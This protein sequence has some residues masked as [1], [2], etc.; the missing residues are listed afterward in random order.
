MSIDSTQAAVP[1]STAPG[2]EQATHAAML[3]N[4]NHS[5]DTIHRPVSRPKSA[6]W[7]GGS[8]RSSL[9]NRPQ[10][11]RGLYSSSDDR[12]ETSS[13]ESLDLD[14]SERPA[15]ARGRHAV[16][17]KSHSPVPT[18]TVLST[19]SSSS[20]SPPLSTSTSTQE[21]L[22]GKARLTLQSSGGTFIKEGN[23]SSEGL[24]L[25]GACSVNNAQPQTTLEEHSDG[26][27]RTS[28]MDR[29]KSAKSSYNRR[30][31]FSE[32]TLATS[33]GRNS[34]A[35]F[36][37]PKSAGKAAF[38]APIYSKEND[39]DFNEDDL[40]ILNID[41]DGDDDDSDD[42]DDSDNDTLCNSFRSN[43]HGLL[44]GDSDENAHPSQPAWQEQNSRYHGNQ[45]NR[46]KN[47]MKSH[48][49]G[50]NIHQQTGSPSNSDEGS[51]Q[52]FI[53]NNPA[54]SVLRIKRKHLRR[55]FMS[56]DSVS[57]S[58]DT[59]PTETHPPGMGNRRPDT[60]PPG[61]R[62]GAPKPQN[63]YITLDKPMEQVGAGGLYGT[64]AAEKV[65]AKCRGR[66]E[67]QGG[68]VQPMERLKRGSTNYPKPK[69]ATVVLNVDRKKH[70]FIPRKLKPLFQTPHE[71][72]SQTIDPSTSS[73]LDSLK[74]NCNKT[75]ST[76]GDAPVVIPESESLFSKNIGGSYVRYDADSENRYGI[77]QNRA[78]ALSDDKLVYN[79]DVIHT[80]PQNVHRN[81]L[82]KKVYLDY[83]N[84]AKLKT[85]QTSQSENFTER[86]HHASTSRFNKQ[87]SFEERELGFRHVSE[88]FSYQ[89]TGRSTEKL[90]P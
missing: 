47:E 56:D 83:E 48:G 41:D 11:S 51:G 26:S 10:S 29:P 14:V 81:K 32:S 16:R 59:S 76:E 36:E 49:N 62:T 27:G 8:R 46:I 18:A 52:V 80:S 37:R 31:H 40:E 7:S 2:T 60:P 50:V 45:I 12:S 30:P 86:N 1:Y 68:S 57:D 75:R 87:R 21:E 61:K 39:D 53:D 74:R 44:D 22:K 73:S 72:D 67:A 24:P 88:D 19:S 23:S 54:Q 5:S 17:R 85:Q 6:K 77:Y 43:T 58:A 35:G 69:P 28:R 79:R 38:R 65:L 82:R 64:T 4:N 89:R 42:S 20:S 25:G 55:R 78:T 70:P 15:S 13:R 63:P 34:V 66:A 3:D 90:H 9:E 71:A 84:D 33:S